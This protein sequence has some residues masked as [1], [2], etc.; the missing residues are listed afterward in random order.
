MR[1][2]PTFGTIGAIA[3]IV[4]NSIQWKTEKDVDI[5]IIFIQKDQI[6]D[7]ILIIDN[8]KGMGLD[9]K[10]KEIIDYCLYFGGGTNHG[11]TEG[12]GKFGIGLPYACC[13]QSTEYHIYTWES[14]NKIKHVGRNHADFKQDDLIE[15][16]PHN[17]IN[18]FPKY[19]ENYLP[20]LK[21]Y[22]SGTIVHWKNCDRL[23]YK[24]ANTIITHLENKLGRIYR[25]FIGNGITI[26][27][28][29]YNQP[30]GNY[31]SVI[32]DLC[33]P[34]RKFDPLFLETGTIADQYNDGEPTSEMFCPEETL[35]FIDSD[36]KKHEFKIRASIA[37]EEIEFPNGGKGGQS[38]LGRLYASVQGVS[39]VRA[40]RELK[41][42]DF[43][44]PFPNNFAD[45]RHRWHKIELLFEPK[46]DELLGVNANKTDALNFRYIKD[47]QQDISVDYIKLRYSLSSL[48]QNRIKDLWDVIEAR[49][50]ANTERKQQKLQKCPKCNDI[51]LKNGKCTNEACGATVTT[52][53]VKG[54]ENIALTNGECPACRNVEPEP[55]CTVHNTTFNEKGICPECEET[56]PLVE[57]EINELVSILENYREFNGDKD[58]IRSLI[59]WFAKSNKKQF[60]VFVSNPMNSSQFFEIKPLPG[61]F[62]I[63]LVNKSHPFYEKHIGPLRELS[64]SGNSEGDYNFEEALDSLVLFIISWAH[65]ERSSTAD[66]GQLKRFRQRFGIN[67][68]EIMEVWSSLS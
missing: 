7:E 62:D 35:E 37:K 24:R 48:I 54:H 43:G 34:I 4:D 68:N 60:I 26:N 51:S 40:N 20:E 42:S 47:E 65:T 8:G 13:S 45:Q 58:S 3:E 49:A 33:K 25:H 9:S 19:F 55:L 63:I 1:S 36:G 14:K 29:A 56:I 15:D 2:V 67:L 12:L 16:K 23:T 66:Q 44:F 27:F 31:P 59:N 22:N 41:I 17:L 32:D 28:K 18:S 30:K 39:L 64:A 5:N 21:K 53:Q 6:L 11:A 10:K 38:K 46:S 50:K 57:D 52:C 61:K